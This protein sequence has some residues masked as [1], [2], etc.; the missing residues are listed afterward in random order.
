MFLATAG[1]SPSHVVPF[2]LRLSFTQ[3]LARRL[4][5]GIEE[6]FDDAAAPGRDLGAYRHAGAEG[7]VALVDADRRL[8]EPDARL[9]DEATLLVGHSVARNEADRAGESAVA[10]EGEGLD[11]HFGALADFDQ[12]NVLVLEH[13]LDL[14]LVVAGRDNHQR[15]RRGHD[16]AHGVHGEL[17]HRFILSPESK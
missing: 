11:L 9:E 10:G 4:A 17:L 15:L 16:S 1:R 7:D 8:V 5:D 3:S 13:G 6:E 12:A 2:F 14:G